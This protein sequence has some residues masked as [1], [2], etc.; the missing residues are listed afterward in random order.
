MDEI[1]D[2]KTYETR[3]PQFASFW[4]RGMA[5]FLDAFLILLILY[6]IYL[7]AG[8]AADFGGF[9]W[10]YGWQEVCAV[11][12]YF[13]YFEGGERNATFGKQIMD[14]RLLNEE[15]RDIGFLDSAKH[16]ILSIVLIPGFFTLFLNEKKQT[17]ADKFCKIVVIR[18]S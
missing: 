16:L 8:N 1:L 14:I 17:W 6:G 7:L 3:T 13:I 11:S 18:R 5:F 4:Q 12:F 15:K 10:K 2:E 9:L